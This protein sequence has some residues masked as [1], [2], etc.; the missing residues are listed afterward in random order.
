MGRYN[1][2]TGIDVTGDLC[3]VFEPTIVGPFL[4]TMNI[5]TCPPEL[6]STSQKTSCIHIES[7]KNV[8]TYSAGRLSIA[9]ISNSKRRFSG[10]D[11]RE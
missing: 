1:K 6:A 3:T 11:R 10:I 7:N 9:R 5:H 4:A 2:P 8:F